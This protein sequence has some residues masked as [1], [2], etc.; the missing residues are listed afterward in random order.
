MDRVAKLPLAHQPGAAWTYGISHD[1]LG[2]LIEVVS[3]MRFDAFLQ[4]RIFEPLGMVDTGFVVPAENL[5]RLA[6]VYAP[7]E[8]GGLR[9]SGAPG[10]DRSEPRAFL[11]GGGGLVSTAG[12]YAQFCQML[13]NGGTLG[14]T[15]V[16]GAKTI[17]LMTATQMPRDQ[18]PFVPATW[19]FRHGYGM[20]LGVRTL[21]DVAQSGIP[22]TA[23]TY[24]W[25][26]AAGTDFWIDPAEE[27]FGIL[28]IQ[29]LPGPHRPGEV[30]RV[31]TYQALD[32]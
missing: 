10:L 18:I 22:G 30:L 24:T 17:E 23:G 5:A 19:P 21:I 7:D 12:D 14:G 25:Q 20:A 16:L 9:R 28:L 29:V 31:L 26:G 2:R 1:V 13:L 15:R 11:S 32:E 8:S 27:L 6:T 4:E 3:G